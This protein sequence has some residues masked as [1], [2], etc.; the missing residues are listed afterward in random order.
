MKI[1]L[2]GV[3]FS[4]VIERRDERYYQKCYL[5]LL[6]AVE[7]SL[8]SSH[9][10]GQLVSIDQS[11]HLRHPAGQI[12]EVSSEA[13]QP[14]ERRSQREMLNRAALWTLITYLPMYKAAVC[15]V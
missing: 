13:L 4:A 7:Q 10:I 15:V 11:F 12:P 1:L 14:G 8:S 5:V 2:H 3:L 9:V 6:V